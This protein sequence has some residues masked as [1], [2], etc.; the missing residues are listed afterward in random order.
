MPKVE[1]IL[2]TQR[3][4]IIKQPKFDANQFDLSFAFIVKYWE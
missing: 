2:A 3:F 4:W 1:L